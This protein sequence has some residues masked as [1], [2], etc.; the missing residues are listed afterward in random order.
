MRQITGD[1]FKTAVDLNADVIVITTN[2]FV[3]N[4]GTAVMGR[5]VA[6][7]AARVW[8]TLPAMLGTAIRSTGNHV[9]ILYVDDGRCVVTLPVKNAWWENADLELIDRSVLELVKWADESD[10]KVI[11]LPRPGCANGRL[12]WN[13]VRPILEKSLDDRFVVAYKEETLS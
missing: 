2:G 12:D 7:T 8:P 13:D 4:D 10:W 3:K 5:G 11:V 1:L 9:H 6:L